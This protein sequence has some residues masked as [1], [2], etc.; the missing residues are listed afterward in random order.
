MLLL[1]EGDKYCSL[2]SQHHGPLR[3]NDPLFFNLSFRTK[4]R[5]LTV[6]PQRNRLVILN[7]VKNLNSIATTIP[8]QYYQDPSHSKSPAERS[9]GG[10][11]VC[12]SDKRPVIPNACHSE[13]SEES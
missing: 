12:H 11:T 9:S 4:W 10:Q 3:T 1:A 2:R 6:L 7:E 8:T 13:W 5:I